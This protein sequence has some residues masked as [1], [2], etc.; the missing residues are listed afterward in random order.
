VRALFEWLFEVRALNRPPGNLLRIDKLFPTSLETALMS[1]NT[2]E[3][4]E[5]GPAAQFIRNCLRFDP[6]NRPSAKELQLNNW[7]FGAFA[8]C[9]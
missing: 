2:L 7:L 6:A 5:I 9:C 3:V 8:C 1:H 4:S